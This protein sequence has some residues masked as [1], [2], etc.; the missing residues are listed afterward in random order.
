MKKHILQRILSTTIILC[1]FWSVPAMAE[2]QNMGEP[3]GKKESGAL[4]LDTMVVTA[5]KKE[6]KKLKV[7]TNVT[8]L[9]G[10]SMEDMGID[11]IEE[12]TDFAPNFNV[13]KLTSHGSQMVFRGIGGV[14]YMSPTFNVNVDDVTIPY[15]A[16]DI[17]FDAQQVELMRGGQG[18][19]YGRNTHAGMLN[20]V[21]RKPTASFCLDSSVSWESFHTGKAKLA[22]G[23]PINENNRYRLAL[24][25]TTT[26]GYM[27]NEFLGTDDGLRQEQFTGRFS[28]QH[29]SSEDS[30]ILFT[31]LGDSYE[32]G[33][34]GYAPIIADGRIPAKTM[35]N[36]DGE[37]EGH[38]LSPT[39][40]WK[41]DFSGAT[42]TS[43][44]N[45]SNSFF[46][47]LFDYDASPQDVIMQDYE[48]EWSVFTQELRLS[49]GKEDGFKWLVGAMATV[50]DYDLLNDMYGGADS[51]LPYLPA[52]LHTIT[53][54]G[55]SSKG[56]AVYGRLENR[57]LEKFEVGVQLRL[58]YE[59]R[60][61]DWQTRYE[62][63]G[64]P[65]MPLQNYNTEEDWFAV[66]PSFD[67]SYLLSENQR[68]YGT[69]SRGYRG[70][71]FAA[72]Q[73]S[74][75]AVKATVEPEYTITYEIGYKGLL[76]DKRFELDAALF[77]I[78]WS[79]MQV[80]ITDGTSFLT[81]NA[82]EATS[83]GF[84][85]E[86]RWLVTEGFDIFASAGWFCGDFDKYDNHPSSKDLSGNK[87]PN[88]NEYSIS[89]G[90]RYRHDSG[91]FTSL[92]ASYMGPKYMDELNEIKQDAYAL[93][94][95]K[96]GYEGEKWAAYVYGR[97][98]LDEEYLLHTF[99][100]MSFGAS[101]KV[102]EGAVYGV[103]LNYF[104]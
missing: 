3:A 47:Y 19:L 51:R 68:F 59:N 86:S 71:D 16:V 23:G 39:L 30:E 65:V 10:F 6:K 91:L 29:F 87:L 17:F 33:F 63:G 36:K 84:E 104:F 25:Y 66:M 32:A 7:A 75:D 44:T 2:R 35:S 89:L 94:H 58:D 70:G 37:E 72:A 60:E 21:T 90:A 13:D 5:Q 101:G 73:Y 9:D 96:I 82:A 77:Y 74:L 98:L 41:K 52:G 14:T 46:S 54:S 18:A 93:V 55:I 26:D 38:L 28:Y 57:F 100:N 40:T 88:A 79:D 48:D 102:A 22:F 78:D 80:S 49:G 8:A 97:N 27:E 95:A 43:I 1:L 12:F 62:M 85:L 67:L 4:E 20:V 34:G 24:G 99:G 81:Q 103:Q 11:D 45:Y 76:A 61:L 69:V 92:S 53:N 15:S 56:A 83:Y 50:E 31:L 64:V 42:L